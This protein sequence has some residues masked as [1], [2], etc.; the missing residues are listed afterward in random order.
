MVVPTA[1]NLSSKERKD[2]K[3]DAT[4]D[5]IPPEYKEKNVEVG[6]TN[7]SGGKNLPQYVRFSYG[8]GNVLNEMCTTLWFTY[9]LVYL[10]YVA[11][12]NNQLSGM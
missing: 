12:M 8:M 1:G 2:K 9:L 11:E 3:I 10:N 7:P 5:T 6:A 4:I